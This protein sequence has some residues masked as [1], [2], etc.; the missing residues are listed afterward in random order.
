MFRPRIRPIW[1]TVAFWLVKTA[2]VTGWEQAPPLGVVHTHYLRRLRSPSAASP[3]PGLVH[4]VSLYPL[5]PF[6]LIAVS[7][8]R[9]FA[10]VASPTPVYGT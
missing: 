7:P 10:A 6:D 4:R 2:Q 8:R 1:P 5:L 9:H 3:G